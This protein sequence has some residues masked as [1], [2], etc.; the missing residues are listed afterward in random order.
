MERARAKLEYR[1]LAAAFC[2]PEFTVF[3]LRSVYETAWGARLDP[4]N[5][6]RK[7]TT[8]DGFL[9]LTG[10]TTE[11]ERGRPARRYR[12]ADATVLYPRLLR[13]E[14]AR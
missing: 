1:A 9:A 5:F 11:G 13:P 4:R 6:H 8:T 3:E 10:G 12:R 2:R 7:A 14:P